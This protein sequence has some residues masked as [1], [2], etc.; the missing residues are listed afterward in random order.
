M[1]QW[2]YSGSGWKNLKSK[3][4]CQSPFKSKCWTVFSLFRRLE[5][6]HHNLLCNIFSTSYFLGVKATTSFHFLMQFFNFVRQTSYR[7]GS[8]CRTLT[9]DLDALQFL[10]TSWIHLHNIESL[11][12]FLSQGNQ[13]K[14]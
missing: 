14:W 12:Y 13:W 5:E 9:R 7:T 4:S 11:L 6:G 2:R 1:A 8:F 3:I 10:Q